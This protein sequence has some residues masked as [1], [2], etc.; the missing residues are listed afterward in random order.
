MLCYVTKCLTENAWRRRC[1]DAT[2]VTKPPRHGGKRHPS[3]P[4]TINTRLAAPQGCVWIDTTR[5]QS[6]KRKED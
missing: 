4:S 2:T 5:S 6:Y 3:Q 1:R